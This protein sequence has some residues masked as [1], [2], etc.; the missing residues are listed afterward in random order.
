MLRLRIPTPSPP[1]LKRLEDNR[2]GS[3]R[4][5][6]GDIVLGSLSLIEEI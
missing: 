2:E 4:L 1:Q 6:P 3:G 5:E